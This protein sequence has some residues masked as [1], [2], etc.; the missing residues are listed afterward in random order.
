MSKTRAE[1]TKHGAAVD[2]DGQ[3]CTIWTEALANVAARTGGTV[4][5]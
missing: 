4:A 3:I 1:T 2:A 5:R